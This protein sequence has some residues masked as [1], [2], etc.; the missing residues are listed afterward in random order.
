MY[1]LFNIRALSEVIGKPLPF[2]NLNE[3]RDRLSEVCPSLVQYGNREENNFFI[4]SLKLSEVCFKCRIICSVSI[5]LHSPFVISIFAG[6][7]EINFW[8][9]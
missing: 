6:S 9:V 3:V 2:D 4:Q 8:T 7:F 5:Y 1:F